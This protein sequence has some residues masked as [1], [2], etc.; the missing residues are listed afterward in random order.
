MSLP[1]TAVA[2][3]SFTTCADNYNQVQNVKLFLLEG[4]TDGYS[5]ARKW[6][7]G[8]WMYQGNANNPKELACLIETSTGELRDCDYGLWRWKS[9]MK[10]CT[11]PRGVDW[12]YDPMMPTPMVQ[13]LVVGV[14]RDDGTWME[15]DFST[16]DAMP[17]TGSCWASI[18]HVYTT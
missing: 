14:V 11:D 8:M 1:R 3:G 7:S 6:E 5:Y 18:G 17:L 4:E 10:G 16:P 13:L 15:A 9:N 12:K 2:W